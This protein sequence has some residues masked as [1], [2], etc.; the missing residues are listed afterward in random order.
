[1]QEQRDSPQQDHELHHDPPNT[2]QH[3]ND[4]DDDD[5]DTDDG[6]RTSLAF[7]VEPPMPARVKKAVSFGTNSIR[8]IRTSG[9]AD[10]AENTT[11]TRTNNNNDETSNEYNKDAVGSS[12]L[13]P[14]MS[15]ETTASTNN[16]HHPTT[17]T[18]SRH[19][20]NHKRRSSSSS[21][22][23]KY[24]HH[25]HFDIATGR[26]ATRYQ[27][28]QRIAV[29]DDDDD[30]SSLGRRFPNARTNQPPPNKGHPK[31]PTHLLY[32]RLQSITPLKRRGLFFFLA[33]MRY[34]TVISGYLRWTF[35]ASF[36]AVTGSAIVAS[37][38]LM[39][40]FA[41][42]IFAVATYQPYCI[43][44]VTTPTQ[45]TTTPNHYF[46][47]SFHLSWTTLT[48]VGY[49]AISPRVLHED[50]G[51]ERWYVLQYPICFSS[52]SCIVPTFL[53]EPGQDVVDQFSFLPFLLMETYH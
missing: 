42:L 18:N 13:A 23:N 19:H 6:Y 50:S 27:R 46:M 4:D 41:A 45:D 8:S 33:P 38:C 53:V 47:D 9:T 1:M 2:Q 24:P 52:I 40:L 26:R 11:T 22:Y 35:H 37:A 29:T 12:T 7:Q 16:Y 3:D 36:W 14:F 10:S 28:I 39:L 15:A 31:R 21:G 43:V 32:Y 51:A 25:A 17:T 20:P 48:T 34:R 5:D 44:V 49:G 30:D